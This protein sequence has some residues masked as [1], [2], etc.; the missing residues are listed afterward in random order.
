MGDKQKKRSSP[1]TGHGASK[2]LLIE[3][4]P[5]T[6]GTFHRLLTQKE[7]DVDMVESIIKETDFDPCVE[8]TIED[9]GALGLFDLSRVHPFFQTFFYSV[10][11]SL[12]DG[13]LV[14]RH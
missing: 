3:T 7:H 6:Q 12:A 5:V 2:G 10:F 1:K 14:F 4:G 8:Q 11:H 13:C 9:L